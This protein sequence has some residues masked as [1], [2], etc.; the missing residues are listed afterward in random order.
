MEFYMKNKEVIELLPST[1]EIIS[2][3]SAVLVAPRK[4]EYQ[5]FKMTSLGVNEILV[6]VLGVGMCASTIPL[7][8][9]RDWF[10]YPLAPGAPGH[11]GWG[12]VVEKGEEV[13]TF[14]IGQR[15]SYLSGNAFSEYIKISSK[16]AVLLPDFMDNMDFPGEPFGCLMNI[17]DRSDIQSGQT[18]AVIG[19]GFLGQGLVELISQRGAKV[20]AISR[21]KSA[22]DHAEKADLRILMKDHHQILSAVS[23]FTEGKG[24]D[25]VIEC[26]G[27][28]WPLD[29]AGEIIGEYGKLIIAGYHQ[30]GLRNVN[31]QQWNWKALD[32][33]NAHE[34]NADV[35]IQGMEKAIEAIEQKE[36]DPTKL[37]THQYSFEQ[38]SVAFQTLSECPE[39]YIKGVIKLNF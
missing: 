39:G 36:L 12:L 32:V 11:E 22:L 20:I 17:F 37:I 2:Y 9:G 33:I 26:T 35:Y 34:R 3:K 28:Q 1:T 18:V 4:I 6:Q 31:L 10:S 30:D 29:I 7:W 21:R 24:C 23:Q 8:E 25:R 13:S 19:L 27:K 16:D 38:L 5:T 15:V 14:E